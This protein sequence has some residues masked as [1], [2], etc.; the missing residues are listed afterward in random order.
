MEAKTFIKEIV[1]KSKK[2]QQV[3]EAFDQEQLD[4]MVKGMAKT[5]Y[6]NRERLSKEAHEETGLGTAENKI[7]K[8][9]S[10]TVNQWNFLKGKKSTGLIK[11]DKEL[12]LLTY[13]KPMG[14]IGSLTPS[15][16]PTTTATHNALISVKS[17]NSIIVSPHPKAKRC[18]ALAVQLM[19]EAIIAAGGP[20][21]L[22]MSI[23]EP[24]IELTDLLMKE[25]DVVVA[26]GGFGMVKAAY[27]SGRPS[28]GVGQG[29]VQTL[30]DDSLED[31]DTAVG[32]VIFNRAYDLG[33]PCTG[34]QTIYIPKTI[35]DAVLAA[36]KAQ[37]A[38]IFD[39]EATIDKFR[40]KAFVDSHQN[41][42]IVG[43]PAASVAKTV[44]IEGVPEETK[45]L[46]FK[47]EKAGKDEPLAKE[48]L[49][50]VVRYRIYEDFADAVEWARTNL[51]M[52]GAGHTATLF[53]TSQERIR[54]AGA[55]LP[56]GRVMVNQGGAAASGGPIN[57]GLE[58][59]ISLGCGSWGNN[60]ISENLTY[61][62]LMNVT[63]VSSVIP[64]VAPLDPE[65]VFED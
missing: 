47:V 50:P 15:T 13:A 43:H 3:V 54:H 52:E 25:V 26:T 56:V 30:F 41:L 2:A 31:I 57:N 22:V 16:N 59:T 39:D 49:C 53:S 65:K 60:S 4:A 20:E 6:D 29:N 12:A 5:I 40:K 46:L 14:V 64:D 11:E 62:H 36:F 28:F 45:L 9:I 17:G 1:A 35:A 10:L 32:T 7:T 24:T 48:I 37:G 55:R 63:R 21:N 51:L 18:T 23:E 38:A 19:N 33:L 8:H 42:E 27:S 34:D 58:P 44:G 61:H